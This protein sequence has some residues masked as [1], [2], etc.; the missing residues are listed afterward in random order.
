ME[1]LI[2]GETKKPLEHIVHKIR[3]M[4]GTIAQNMHSSLAAVISTSE[5]VDEAKGDIKEAFFR[6]IQVIPEEFLDEVIDYYDPIALIVK[7]DLSA[8]GKDVS[9]VLKFS[10]RFP[11]FSSFHA[12]KLHV[13]NDF[14][15][16]I[17]TF[18]RSEKDHHHQTATECGSEC[19]KLELEK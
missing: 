16:A 1:F 19:E 2:V 11:I 13:M 14:I 17:R 5:Q 8:W 4:G 6:R 18:A 9:F 15:S 7:N 10:L 12:W 3:L